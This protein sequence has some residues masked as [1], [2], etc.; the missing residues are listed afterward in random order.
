MER[1]TIGQASTKEAAGITATAAS[2]TGNE[3]SG[4][5]I[6]LAEARTRKDRPEAQAASIRFIN[7]YTG[8]AGRTTKERLRAGLEAANE[9]LAERNNTKGVSVTA[10]AIHA[11]RVEYIAAGNGTVAAWD[12]NATIVLRTARVDPRENGR[13]AGL[14]Q[15]SQIAAGSFDQG[16]YKRKLGDQNHVMLGSSLAS[17]LDQE[18]LYDCRAAELGSQEAA[19]RLVNEVRERTRNQRPGAVVI[20]ATARRR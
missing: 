19:D 18:A 11:D 2:V 10:A 14:L 9:A 7:G 4:S 3:A 1:I 16:R 17:V 8:G 20:V 13:P 6:C 15:G 5:V 12:Q